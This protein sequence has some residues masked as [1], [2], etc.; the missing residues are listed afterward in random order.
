MSL[1]SIDDVHGSDSLSLGML[2]VSDGIPNDV[3]KEALE[4]LSDALVDVKSDSLNTT[5]AGQSSDG[6]L[7]DAVDQRTVALLR[8]TLVAS[9][10]GSLAAFSSFSSASHLSLSRPGFI[11]V[12]WIFGE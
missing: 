6:R 8:G 9:L 2:G 4:D 5:T 7:G 10:S 1:Q 11:Y 3:F 12:I